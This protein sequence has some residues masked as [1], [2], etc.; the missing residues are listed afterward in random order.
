M[1]INTKVKNIII[2]L[3]TILFIASLINEQY[4]YSSK[5]KSVDN[6]KY[7][8]NVDIGN[9]YDV[10][11][12]IYDDKKIIGFSDTKGLSKWLIKDEVYD[13]EYKDKMWHRSEIIIVD[14]NK[15]TE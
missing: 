2:L 7:Q 4:K 3:V 13:I 1:K 5:T 14:V 9:L 10:A 6:L 12:F 8:G 11:I 15:H